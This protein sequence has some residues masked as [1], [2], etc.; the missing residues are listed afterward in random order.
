[1]SPVSAV[2]R[3]NS[4][5]FVIQLVNHEYFEGTGNSSGFREA[6]TIGE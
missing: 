2:N 6:L 1:M 4:G 5:W 3:F